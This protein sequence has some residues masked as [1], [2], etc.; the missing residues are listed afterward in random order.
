VKLNWAIAL[1]VVETGNSDDQDVPSG[2]WSRYNIIRQRIPQIDDPETKN[3][4]S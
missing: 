1:L 2:S 3:I 4:G